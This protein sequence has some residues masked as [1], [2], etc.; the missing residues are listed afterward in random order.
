M[1]GTWIN[2]CLLRPTGDGAWQVSYR[3][4]LTTP[5]QNRDGITSLRLYR[6]TFKTR[7]EA[8]L[9]A[10]SVQLDGSDDR[11]TELSGKDRNSDHHWVS[12]CITGGG[13]PRN[14]ARR[15]DHGIVERGFNG[16]LVDEMENGTWRVQYQDQNPT[17]AQ[18]RR[19]FLTIGWHQRSFKTRDEAIAFANSVPRLSG[20]PGCE[21]PVQA[22]ASSVLGSKA[23]RHRRIAP[24]SRKVW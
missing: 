3:E 23:I 4:L 13:R 14:T 6:Q 10:K 5:V 24:K 7:K 12:K 21:N 22:L 15:D 20:S 8:V 17:P 9:Y 19:G 2:G 1:D 11:T 16:C 18:Q